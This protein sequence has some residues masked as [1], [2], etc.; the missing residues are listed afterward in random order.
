[1]SVAPASVPGM[2]DHAATVLAY[3]AA[4]KARDWDAFA[5][6]LS[7]DVVY[8]VPQTRERIVGREAYVRFNQDYPGDW[9][10]RLRRIVADQGGAASWLDFTVRAE[11][12]PGISFFGFDDD[13]LITTV[14]D[15]WPEPY[16]PPPGREHLVERY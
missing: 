12:M 13:C 8:D 4:A 5:G 2:T 15:F 7:P 1:M 3:W 9:R 6:L 10:V 16:D 11:T 14:D